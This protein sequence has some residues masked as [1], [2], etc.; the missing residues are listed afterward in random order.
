MKLKVT[1]F[2]GHHEAVVEPEVG[3]ALFEKMT[4]RN[5]APLPAEIRTAV[6]ETFGELK[7]LWEAGNPGYSALAVSE[8]KNCAPL[9]EFDPAAQEVLFLAPVAGG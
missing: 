4:G 3:R 2:R 9:R 1:S 7:A 5:K 6:P 8:D